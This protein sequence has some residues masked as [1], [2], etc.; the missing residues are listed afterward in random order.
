M[1]QLYLILSLAV[2]AASF[3]QEM[4]PFRTDV[5]RKPSEENLNRV[6]A[7]AATE[8]DII[9][10][11][12]ADEADYYTTGKYYAMYAP[13]MYVS[14]D[15]DGSIVKIA[16]K[17]GYLYI[18]NPFSKFHTETYIQG[19]IEGDI[20]TFKF[21]QAVYAEG[22]GEVKEISFANRMYRGE[23]E[24]GLPDYF[25]VEN[26][27]D[28][29]IQFKKEGNNWVMQ[30]ST[31]EGENILGLSDEEG[32]WKCYGNFATVYE[33][34][35]REVEEVPAGLN[36]EKWAMIYS[37][38]GKYVDVAFDGDDVY[39]RGYAEAMPDAWVKGKVE[40]DKVV[41]PNFQYL[42]Y[43]DYYGAVT[44]FAGAMPIKE[45]NESWQQYEVKDYDIRDVVTFDYDSAAKSIST[46]ET[47]ILSVSYNSL[48]AMEM[49]EEPAFRYQPEDIS[50]V[51]A[52]PQIVYFEAYNPDMGVGGIQIK[53]ANLNT[54]G[55]LLDAGK[56]YYRYYVDGV[57]FELYPDEY[58]IDEPMTDIPFNFQDKFGWIMA[59]NDER[60]LLF[61]VDGF[62]TMGVQ[63]LYI[64][65]D[66]TYSSEIVNYDV[67]A[68]EEIPAAEIVAKDYYNLAGIKVSADAKGILL[69]VSRHADGSKTVKKV[70][71][72]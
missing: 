56:M 67:T 18:M 15:S 12:D 17:D 36:P 71:R 6:K 8:D 9:Y 22:S 21:P 37:N 5:F 52:N 20:A 54:E 43:N 63:Q 51:P 29:Y 27:D 32:T 16:E 72:K 57:P 3:A 34:F 41:M 58:G 48:Y 47:V 4:T 50:K 33:P 31:A 46:K 45:W 53:V 10:D 30:S 42:G 11:V 14:G 69:E 26:E 23:N 13:G 39:I 7:A 60:Q 28:N 59:F 2:S 35:D 65:G 1:K 44:F 61:T 62:K 49:Y 68:V 66:E 70:V 55:Q 25:V 40:G 38:T 64:D 19:K 24:Y